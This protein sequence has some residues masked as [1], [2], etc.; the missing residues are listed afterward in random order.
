M[1]IL[2]KD[3]NETNEDMVRNIKLNPNQEGFIETVEECL[4]EANEY[5]EW[6]PVAIYNDDEVI[7]FAMYG[8]FGPN[9]DTWIDRIMIDK[10]Y[11][12]K[13]YGKSAMLNL[14][15]IVSK[16]YGVDTVYLS[17]IEENRIAYELYKS[18]GF[19]Y[20]NEKDI[21]GEL[22]FKYTI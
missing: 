16:K 17:I 7:G 1:N 5:K 22:I 10:K 20:I 19:E 12:G 15:E 13:G 2:F 21:N 11:Q 8:S 3:I 6:C 9:R 18:I 4:R 14:I